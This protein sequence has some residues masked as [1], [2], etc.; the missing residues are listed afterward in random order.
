MFDNMKMLGAMAGLMKNKDKLREA[1]VRV[2]TKMENTRVTG[3]AGGGAA[4]AVVSGTMQ[5]LEVQ[6]SPSLVMGMAGDAKTHE[7]ASGLIAQAVNAAL[8]EAQLK[9][10][11]AIDEESKALGLDGVIPE[12]GNLL[13][14]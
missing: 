4:R 14:Q 2:R 3:E 12:I 6:L 5:V 8:R 1:G 11:A 9:M 13:G 7:L 10:K